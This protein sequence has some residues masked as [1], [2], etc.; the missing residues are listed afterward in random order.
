MRNYSG[1]RL[2]PNIRNYLKDSAL[3]S[4]LGNGLM[5]ARVNLISGNE[6]NCSRRPKVRQFSQEDQAG[7]EVR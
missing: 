4:S 5:R 6:H 2:I 7:L 1:Y 3:P